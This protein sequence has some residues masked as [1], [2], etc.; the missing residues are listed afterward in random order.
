MKNYNFKNTLPY[1]IAI[2][3]LMMIAMWFFNPA[4]KGYAIVQNDIIQS[5]GMTNDINAFRDTMTVEPHWTNGMFSGM[6]STQI[7]VSEQG[8]F[9]REIRKVLHLWMPE[10][11]GQLFLLMA[12]F[13]FMA[14]CMR[15]N[16]WIATV[17][18]IAYGFSS[19][20]IISIEAGHVNK[21]WA[22]VFIAPIVGSF[23]LAYRG[24]LKWGILLSGFFMMLQLGSN[25]VQITYY[26]AMIL[27]ILGIYFLVKAIREKAYKNFGIA[28]FGILALY[29]IAAMSTAANLLPTFEYTAETTRGK[30]NVT[31]T[32]T[33]ESNADN[34]TSGL[35][36]DYIV[37][38]SLGKS[39]TATLF[40]PYAKGAHFVAIG[41]GELNERLQE[42]DEFNSE[43][44]QFIANSVQYYGDQPFTSG[45]VYIGSLVFLLAILG[46]FFID[47]GIKW[48]FLA[49]A[50]LS[51]FLAWGKN[52][53]WF[54]DLFLDYVPMYSKF[55]AVTM[56]LIILELAMPILMILMLHQLWQHRDN[57]LSKK[58]LF[59]GITGGLF[60]LLTV[61]TLSPNLIG[62]TS[63]EER[64]KQA[65]PQEVIFDEIARQVQMIPPQQLV[66]YG[67]QN[68]N[69]QQEIMNFVM[70][71][72]ES[73]V[74]AF[75]RNFPSLITFRK[76]IYN[77]YGTRSLVFVFL[78][79]VLI[80][81]HLFIP[82]I[83][84]YVMTGGLG[85]LIAIDLIGIN[86]IFMPNKGDDSNGEETVYAKWTPWEEQRYPHT[87][88]PS[89]LQILEAEMAANPALQQRVAKAENSAKQFANEQEYSLRGKRNYIEN[90]RFMA[91][92]S[93]TRHRMVDY[94]DPVFSSSRAAYFHESVGGYHGAKLQRYQNLI[95]FNYLP[96]DRSILNM[97]N[98][99]YLVRGGQ[100]E[101]NAGAMGNVW[102]ATDLYTA[103]DEN[104]E[105]LNLGKRYFLNNE[106]NDWIL[107]VNDEK[108][109]ETEVYARERIYLVKGQ[110]S[111]QLRWPDGL[112]KSDIA[113]FVEDARG[114]REWIP[115]LT[116]ESD[117]FDSFK[118]LIRMEVKHNFSP[119]KLTIIPAESVKNVRT[120]GYNGQGSVAL[121]K[122]QL[123]HLTYAFDSQDEQLVVFSEMYYKPGWTAFVDG[124]EVDHLRVNYVLRGL[125]VPAGKHTIEFKINDSTYQKGLVFARISSWVLLLL[126]FGAAAW[127]LKKTIS[128]RKGSNSENQ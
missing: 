124:K 62:M 34:S 40:N 108:K 59:L 16:V 66:Q 78:G 100:V 98:V 13:F 18:A 43:E 10:H 119:N 101:M 97:L 88:K 90:K 49:V 32:P 95:E 6:P 117:E 72:T 1:L 36:R 94:D 106:T 71:V 122:H 126:L 63:Q 35:D 5:K 22:I 58:P 89:D 69:D 15:V 121:T 73:Q 23:I 24:F 82:S 79:L 96:F 81:L 99:K 17:G 85:L 64:A 102:L 31:I 110:D 91:Y 55:R 74:Q 57:I 113:Y 25:H 3:L 37:Q 118:S 120:K 39:E 48:A 46:L 87:P 116:F 29:G 42:M 86:L 109:K 61:L 44:R 107:V 105:I 8:H 125:V 75:E 19:F 45:P 9:T 123:N 65:N 38:W 27:S 11:I 53:M 47:S 51:L 30:N 128:S 111:I 28:T 68:P 76:M 104:D 93:A 83:N 67:I 14:L 114:K 50:L 54:T 2:A 33:L 41:N 77:S 92:R 12:G 127:D 26:T 70:Q 21:V 103:K 7:S 60:G 84:R 80:L 4:L 52:M 56:I 115:Q 20:F 112:N